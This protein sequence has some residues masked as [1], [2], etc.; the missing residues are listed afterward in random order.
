MTVNLPFSAFCNFIEKECSPHFLFRLKPEKLERDLDRHAESAR[1]KQG[2][3][4]T[5][6]K[7]AAQ[8]EVPESRALEDLFALFDEVRPCWGGLGA[9][10]SLVIEMFFRQFW[11]QRRGDQPLLP[12]LPATQSLGVFSPQK[13]L[14]N[15]P[16]NLA[17]NQHLLINTP[18]VGVFV[19]GLPKGL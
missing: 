8:L 5:L 3:S 14:S 15:A 13:M 9:A 16:R 2:G 6:P 10:V 18:V 7:F 4:L 11:K 12:I 1:M 17:L 19:S